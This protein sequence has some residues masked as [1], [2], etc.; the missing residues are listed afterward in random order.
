[1]RLDIAG[2]NMPFISNNLYRG[3]DE[4]ARAA[5]RSFLEKDASLLVLCL[6]VGEDI[7]GGAIFNSKQSGAFTREHADLVSQLREPFDI[8]CFQ[9]TN[10]GQGN[11]CHAKQTYYINSA[12]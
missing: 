4:E 1:M 12:C 9:H 11:I 2:K 8:T 5:S 3:H 10:E 6:I 7:V